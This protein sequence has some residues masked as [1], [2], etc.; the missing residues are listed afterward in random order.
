MKA[1]II[2]LLTL[3]SVYAHEII[4]TQ[5]LKG[6]KKTKVYINN[7]KTTCE[8]DVE[9]VRNLMEEDSFGNPAYKVR[10]TAE[11]NGKD[12]KRKIKIKHKKEFQMI[13]LHPDGEKSRVEDFRYISQEDGAEMEIDHDGRLRSFHFT[14][15]NQ[16]ISCLF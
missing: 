10:V 15:E 5:V 13:N 12:K 9:K 7:V 1:L 2:F 4:G 3:S 8:V 14:F 11:L 6:S 16:K